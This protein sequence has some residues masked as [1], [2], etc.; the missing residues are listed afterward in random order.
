MAGVPVKML[1][2]RVRPYRWWIVAGSICLMG[3]LLAWLVATAPLGRALEPAKQPSLIIT[4]MNGKAIA[5]RGDYKEEPV[6]IARFQDHPTATR[7][8]VTSV[9]TG[10]HCQPLP[11]RK[12]P[13][14]P[15]SPI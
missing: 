15:W 5:R 9:A 13:G 4:D 6:K 11:G 8:S 1:W 12:G 10:H 2:V 3:L 7:T 14:R